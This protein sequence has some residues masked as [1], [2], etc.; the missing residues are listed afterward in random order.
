MKKIVLAV[1]IS[2]I[3]CIAA[4]AVMNR[5]GDAVGRQEENFTPEPGQ[6]FNEKDMKKIQP[7]SEI[8]RVLA[9]GVDYS[10]ELTDV[11]MYVQYDPK[12]M[13]VNLLSIP[14]DS[15][16]G[17]EYVTGKIN[18][19][20]RQ[21]GR[22]EELVREVEERFHLDIDYYATITLEAL[23]SIVDE[24]G[25]IEVTIDD[26]LY[27]YGQLVFSKGTQVLDGE[28]TQLFVRL[29]H[30]YVNADLGRIGAQQKFLMAALDKAQSMGKLTVLRLL[31]KNF[32]ALKTDMPLGKMVS[33]A[34][35]A[36]GIKKEN[37]HMF[38]A[39]GIG[40]MNGEY[41]VYE[42]DKE[43]LAEILNENFLSTPI[44]A[45]DLD[46]PT[47]DA[48]PYVAEPVSSE[49]EVPEEEPE[50]LE[51]PAEEPDSGEEED[52][53]R[54]HARKLTPEEVEA[55]RKAREEKE[56]GEQEY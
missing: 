31:M 40:K 15:Y 55:R 44:T 13:Q 51:E 28:K 33:V 8:I 3:V 9:C 16:L 36:F 34:S 38:T 43:G 5:T 48:P 45:D 21:T 37:I 56:Q 49:E 32:S 47:V 27:D 41:A 11:I 35:T 18:Q 20:Y 17:E 12:T 7:Q 46:F 2:V 1:I 42:V 39:P 6:E 53:G 24:V 19:V 4:V 29:R 10:H 14:R 22:M 26:D 54:P 50:V 30:A 52:D 23:G 25:G